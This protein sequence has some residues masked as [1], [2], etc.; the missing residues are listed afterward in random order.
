MFVPSAK[1]EGNLCSNNHVFENRPGTVKQ[2]HAERDH[3]VTRNLREKGRL[4]PA[5]DSSPGAFPIQNSRAS[6]GLRYLR[7]PPAL[8]TTPLDP[9]SLDEEEYADEVVV[10][11]AEI[12]GIIDT[13]SNVVENRPGTVE[14]CAVS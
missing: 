5:S 4:R 1:T 6:H 2:G 3:E 8:T 12:E 7:P 9:F 11:A 14:A 13:E 10:P